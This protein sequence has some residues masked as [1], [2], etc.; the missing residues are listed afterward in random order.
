MEDF[1]NAPIS[2]FLAVVAILALFALVAIVNPVQVPVVL[3]KASVITL[4]ALLSYLLDYLLFPT[5]RPH[6]V[7]KKGELLQAAVHVR[8]ALITLACVLGMGMAL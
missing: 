8:R 4:G 5:T 6:Q 1:K 3:Y 7:E 2:R